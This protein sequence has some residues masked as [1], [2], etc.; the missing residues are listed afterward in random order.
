MQLFA[1]SILIFSCFRRDRRRAGDG[2]FAFEHAHGESMKT[3][4]KMRGLVLTPETA[5]IQTSA[6]RRDRPRD[7]LLRPVVLCRHDR[8]A[9]SGRAQQ[10]VVSSAT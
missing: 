3:D 7:R 5:K 8:Q 4:N 6:Q 10:A 2:H 1:F 9:W